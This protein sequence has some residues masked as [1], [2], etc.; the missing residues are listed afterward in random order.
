[1]ELPDVNILLYALSGVPPDAGAA[2]RWLQR[3]LESDEPLGLSELVLSGVIRI[4]T[5][6]PFG[7]PEFAPAA[8]A[9]VTDLHDHPKATVIRPGRD[10]W[11]I[12]MELCALPGVTGNRVPDAYHGALAIESGCTWV[13][14]DSGFQRFP[15]L[16]LRMLP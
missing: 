6:A 14:A 3:T 12:F 4:A 15:G 11:R 8:R 2:R 10:H 7:G 16:K 5:R 9:F 1:V 13:T